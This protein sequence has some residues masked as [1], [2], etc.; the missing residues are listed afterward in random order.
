MTH[1]LSTDQFQEN[2]D[3][4]KDTHANWEPWNTPEGA[5]GQCYGASCDYAAGGPEGH[6]HEGEHTSVAAFTG[7][8][9]DPSRAVHLLGEPAKMEGHYAAVTET[10][11]GPQVVD[12]T[13]R[14][15]DSE[16]DFPH[17]RPLEEYSAMWNTTKTG[18]K[19]NSMGLPQ[20]T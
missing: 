8:K 1:R 16:A 3:R 2:V 12:W 4:F 13:A 6:A 15:F 17:V 7:Y 18:V 19:R 5:L 11:E 9:G 14:Q 20:L 10:T